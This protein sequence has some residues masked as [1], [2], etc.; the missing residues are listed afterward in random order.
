MLVSAR[1]RNSSSS[2][3]HGA[4]RRM[5]AMERLERLEAA[6]T[7]RSEGVSIAL[8]AWA[9]DPIGFIRDVLINPETS[10]PFDLYPVQ[11]RFFDEALTAADGRL[12]YPE[13]VY[14]APKKSGKT[15]TAAMAMLYVVLVLGGPYAEGYC[16]ANDYDQATGR[17]F[18]AAARIVERSPLLA[19]RAR[20]FRDRIE[21]PESGTTITAIASDYAGAAG[22]NPSIT[23][24]DELWAYTSE[25]ARRLWDEMV[26]VP[27]RRVSVRLTTTYA[28]FEGESELLE[29]LYKH[30][31]AG[32]QIVPSLYR[33]GGQLM[34]WAHEP[35]APWQTPA[36]LEQMRA[37]LRPNAYLRL[38]ENRFVG[39]ESAFIPVE[40][41]DRAT[42][43][44]PVVADRALPVVLGVDAGLK[45]DSAAV[46][47][48][49]FDERTARVRLVGHRIFTPKE[50]QPLDIEETL[51][52]TVQ[53]FA[54]RFA[55][56]AVF[57]DPWQFQ[58]SA[59]TLTKQGLPM[60]EYQTRP[61]LWLRIA[62]MSVAISGPGA[63]ESQAPP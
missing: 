15:A 38:I 54:K 8:Q 57:F 14:A 13:I 10:L 24:F 28:G 18:Q 61:T 40:W 53:D 52:A 6:G 30:G 19:G 16:V 51:E 42:N 2:E 35:V 37:Q 21:F 23:V 41:W 59:Q 56:S 31:I 43:S 7:V 47:A 22:A 3:G 34:L 44:T 9:S 36:W 46:A 25:S 17:V 55:V 20:I 39:G 60:I 48:C 63:Q 26:P 12:L 11:E 29:Q 4:M 1:S 5:G 33:N 49:T 32:E 50:G 27:T 58:R 62:A 45:R